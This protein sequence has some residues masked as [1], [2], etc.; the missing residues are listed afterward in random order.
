MREIPPQKPRVDTGALKIGRD[1]GIFIRG[2]QCAGYILALKGSIELLKEEG[3]KLE[4]DVLQD[5]LK[6][7][8]EA[9]HDKN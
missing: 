4:V 2:D 9:E 5:L 8:E 1:A 6:V 7:M 3:E